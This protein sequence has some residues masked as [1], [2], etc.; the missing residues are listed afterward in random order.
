M[1]GAAVR[2]RW[3]D[4]STSVLLL[5]GKPYE[6]GVGRGALSKSRGIM[7]AAMSDPMIRRV[8]PATAVVYLVLSLL[9]LDGA[10]GVGA[11]AAFAVRM[12]QDGAIGSIRRSPVRV[13]PL[14]HRDVSAPFRPQL[15]G[16]GGGT[17]AARAGVA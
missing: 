12:H 16:R 7:A 3:F 6:W 13:G 17:Q 15:V 10:A 9:V 2:I 8:L 14:R 5:A 11:T 1:V 4:G